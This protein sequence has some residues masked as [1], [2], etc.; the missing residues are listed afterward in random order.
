[1]M[2]LRSRSG[3]GGWVLR[4][5]YARLNRSSPIKKDARHNARSPLYEM[6]SRDFSTRFSCSR[7][8]VENFTARFLRLVSIGVKLRD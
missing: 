4:A 2:E 6:Q 3:Q 8:F 1:M 5:Q 7:Y